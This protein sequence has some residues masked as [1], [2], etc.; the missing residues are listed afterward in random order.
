MPLIH[1]YRSQLEV[2]AEYFQVPDFICIKDADP[3]F[4]RG[5]D[6]KGRLLGS[7]GTV[8]LIL[9]GLEVNVDRDNLCQK[10]GIEHV[11]RVIKL[12][13]LSKHM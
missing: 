6:D 3:D 2:I 10:Y 13:E 12:R 7:F 9:I 1:L 4:M 8:D 5:V 11:E